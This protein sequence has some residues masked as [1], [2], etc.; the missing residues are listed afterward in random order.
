MTDVENTRE[1]RPLFADGGSGQMG[2]PIKVFS[3]T[4]NL[5][6][7]TLPRQ[8]GTEKHANSMPYLKL[9]IPIEDS[10]CEGG[11]VRPKADRVRPGRRH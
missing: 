11:E 4:N 8:L 6:T 2:I 5:R 3:R 7:Y 9:T 1:P 10:A